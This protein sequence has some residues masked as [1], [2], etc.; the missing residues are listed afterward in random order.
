MGPMTTKT[1]D[2]REAATAIPAT[3]VALI[4]ALLRVIAP[5]AATAALETLERI[6]DSEAARRAADAAERAAFEADRAR[7]IEAET[8]AV[9][10]AEAAERRA[11][12]LARGEARLRAVL[13]VIARTCV[14]VA[15]LPGVEVTGV[16]AAPVAPTADDD[17]SEEDRAAMHP[18][19][20][21]PGPAKSVAT[22]MATAFVQPVRR[23]RDDG[24][25]SGLGAMEPRLQPTT[26]VGGPSR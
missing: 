23:L 25:S 16:G 11:E 9:A 19:V 4:E 18:K 2:C 20:G 1:P 24:R 13:A 6:A 17:A 10:R 5:E 12:A 8:A 15:A 21:E 7:L 14:A 22:T 3:A 26:A